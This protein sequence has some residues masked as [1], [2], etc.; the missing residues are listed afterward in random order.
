MSP[1]PTD[2]SQSSAAAGT[3]AQLFPAIA[4]AWA[5]GYAERGL[6]KTPRALWLH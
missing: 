6:L 2:K 4:L 5:G 1:T 3:V